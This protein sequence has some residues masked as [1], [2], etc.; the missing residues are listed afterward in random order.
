M[1]KERLSRPNKGEGKQELSPGLELNPH[2][3]CVQNFEN[4]FRTATL[5]TTMGVLGY[6]YVETICISLLLPLVRGFSCY[7]KHYNCI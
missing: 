4:L 6:I 5:A 3:K 2:R 7:I 1:E